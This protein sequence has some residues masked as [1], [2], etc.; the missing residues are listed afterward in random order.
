MS[1]LS[2]SGGYAVITGIV[3]VILFYFLLSVL[4]I[5]RCDREN[6]HQEVQELLSLL[7]ERINADIE[8]RAQLELMQF[9]ILHEMQTNT[10]M[11]MSVLGITS[12]RDDDSKK[13]VNNKKKDI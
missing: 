12:T 1:I 8:E 9:K 7:R 2:E 11:L 3:I 6:K 10:T 4:N 5:E 13:S